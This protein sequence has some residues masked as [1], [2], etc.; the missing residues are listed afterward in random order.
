[1]KQTRL[2]HF[3]LSVLFISLIICTTCD[4]R[5]I[6]GNLI[7]YRTQATSQNLDVA[8]FRGDPISKST[9]RLL[10]LAKHLSSIGVILYGNSSCA[11]VKHQLSL[12]GPEAAKLLTYVECDGKNIEICEAAGI[13][14]TPTWV[15]K[16]KQISGIQLPEELETWSGYTID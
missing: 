1:M 3:T 15:F 4:S 9:P 16:D 13:E 5:S 12:F 2:F 11:Y 10:A 6:A 7:K 8:L 14:F